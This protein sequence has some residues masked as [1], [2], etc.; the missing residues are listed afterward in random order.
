MLSKAGK[1]AYE[2]AVSEGF[3]GTEQEWLASLKQPAVEAAARADSAITAMQLQYPDALQDIH[4]DLYA[5]LS[6][7]LHDKVV[8]PLTISDK[9]VLAG[10]YS[11]GGE[12][13][14]IYERSIQMIALPTTEG[15]TK[16]FV[17]A[18][19]PLGLGLYLNIESFIASSGKG[20]T[21]EFFNFNYDIVRM[22]VNESL[23]SCIVVKCKNTVADE[24]NGL[25]QVLGRYRR[26]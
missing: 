12:T 4:D 5:Q 17:I 13:L 22:Y 8:K 23:Q 9:E 21:K 2:A 6:D 26:I 19:E 10:S 11:I 3:T 15:E 7:D 25:L 18:D 1:S 20:L 24:I 16:E 14:D